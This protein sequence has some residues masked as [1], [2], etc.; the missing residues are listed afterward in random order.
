M[1]QYGRCEVLLGG[2]LALL[3]LAV[4]ST[5]AG[6][7]SPAGN[8]TGQRRE[9]VYDYTRGV[10]RSLY[11][12]IPGNAECD[13]SRCEKS[14]EARQETQQR[15][16]EQAFERIDQS[17]RIYQSARPYYVEA[18]EELMEKG[19][20]DVL[21]EDIRFL[22]AVETFDYRLRRYKFDVTLGVRRV[23]RLFPELDQLLR[24][25]LQKNPGQKE[26][27]E[28]VF[29][30]TRIFDQL[31]KNV[32]FKR[33]LEELMRSES[34]KRALRYKDDDTQGFITQIQGYGKGQYSANA[35]I[36]SII[37]RAVVPAVRD[38]LKTHR[39]VTV[40]CEGGTDR[41]RI[42]SPLSY[43]GNGRVTEPGVALSLNSQDGRALNGGIR[44]N[45]ALS[46]ARG[47]EGAR[48]LAEI[49]GPALSSN[50]RI[51]LRYTGVGEV[52]DRS[53]DH[54]ESRRIRF[55]LSLGPKLQ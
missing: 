53:G 39:N 47:Y 46:F 26:G 38:A 20:L 32:E 17:G 25:A 1:E 49:L 41:L 37:E 42:T 27:A 21:R 52:A 35:L 11:L 5:E 14:A 45:V 28:I 43:A 12:E 8:Q 9:V 19:S 48:A 6:A 54:P 51:E 40:T 30:L 16:Y 34:F 7:Q 55:R 3:S 44:D 18:F 10:D 31:S 24:R 33:G 22:K 36:G 2:I 13:L 50:K 15:A 23:P 4:W 29:D